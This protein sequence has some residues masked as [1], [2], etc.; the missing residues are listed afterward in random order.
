MPASLTLEPN[1]Y[2][3]GDS[4]AYGAGYVYGSGYYGGALLI[5]QLT[6]SVLT[7][8]TQS[9]GTLTLTPNS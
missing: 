8:A 1:G 7:I 5:A 3:T 6:L 4:G 9:A 2:G